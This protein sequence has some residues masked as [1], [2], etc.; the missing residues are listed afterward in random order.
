MQMKRRGFLAAGLASLATPM[1]AQTAPWAGVTDVARG[2][3]QC[4]ALII[5]QSGQT[6]LAEH[7]RGPGL[8]RAVPI[9]SVSK[10]F[11]AALTGAAL[12][13]DELPA[14]TAT[15]GDVAPRLI[16]SNADPRVA[17]ITMEN[18]V[19]MQAGLER[20]SGRNYGGWVSSSNWVANALG[21]PFVAEP[22]AGMLY[23]TGSFH[24]LGAVLSEV[25][26]QSLLSLAR[27]R[28]GDPL[29]FEIPAWTRD[30][31]GRY[32]GGNEMALTPD[33][34][35][36]FGEM[37]RLGGQ[38]GGAQVLSADWVT[39]S[40]ERRTQ[41]AFSGLGYGY[42]WFLGQGAGVGYALARGYGGQI[43]CV[44]PEIELTLA[45]TSDP[46]RPARSGGYFGDLQGLIERQILPLAKTLI[47]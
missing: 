9:K 32:L 45:I 39:R 17:E 8:N 22:G 28:L 20:T 4:H 5:R 10:T 23:S 27:S 33:G 43:I 2:F 37:Y 24:I 46:L 34:M 6:V 38:F 16:P 14:L 18:L 41:S 31:Q 11:V 7:Y 13:R 42:G 12:N 15:L 1:L 26:G 30:P 25:S 44:A 36:R 47:S 3:D 19:T 29:G 21:R 40:F 35:I